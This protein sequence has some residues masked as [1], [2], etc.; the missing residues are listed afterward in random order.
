MRLDAAKNIAKF[1]KPMICEPIFE[2]QKCS[3]IFLPI[4]WPFVS[5]IFMIFAGISNSSIIAFSIS[6]GILNIL[7]AFILTQ[8]LFKDEKISLLT[9]LFFSFDKLNGLWTV[10][11]NDFN[12]Q[13]F[14]LL[15]TVIAYIYFLKYQKTHNG[16]LFITSFLLLLYTRPELSLIVIPL[17]FLT[18]FKKLK[19]KKEYKTV[20]ITFMIFLII[21]ILFLP[22]L[23]ETQKGFRA[24]TLRKGL[25]TIE[26][27]KQQIK[28]V[29]NVISFGTYYSIT[30]LIIMLI[31]IIFFWKKH[32][33]EIF[34]LIV[35]MISFFVFYNLTDIK[36]I[37]KYYFVFFI[38][39]I[40]LLSLG[41]KCLINKIQSFKLNKKTNCFLTAF[42]FIIIFCSLIANIYSTQINLK[43]KPILMTHLPKVLEKEL[44][45][46]CYLLSGEAMAFSS[47]TDINAISAFDFAEREDTIINRLQGDCL[48]F[49]DNYY[50]DRGK[51]C[52]YIRENYELELFSEYKHDFHEI[53]I[54]KIII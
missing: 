31:G 25:S 20:I 53:K 48:L 43:A 28:E 19:W 41:I 23:L 1:N 4:G 17:I 7:L 39:M 29:I 26:V 18:N 15:A 16:V 49:V 30:H 13:I 12:I 36:S 51:G 11:A 52:D 38:P 3:K 47:L 54:Y 9:A 10:S 22:T 5:S 2:G 21:Q 50:C 40:I 37:H 45:K 14:F 44:P 27:F 8:L 35:W 34:T 46:D 24:N 32:K 6:I 33:K 42:I